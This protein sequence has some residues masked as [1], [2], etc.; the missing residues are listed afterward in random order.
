MTRVG[1]AMKVRRL[2]MGSGLA[3]ASS[4]PLAKSALAAGWSPGAVLAIRLSGAAAIM[5][6][7]AAFSDPIGLRGSLHHPRT[8]GGSPPARWSH[9]SAWRARHASAPR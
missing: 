5:L 2:T 8:V 7:V 6:T 3:F 1:R 4:G 9:I